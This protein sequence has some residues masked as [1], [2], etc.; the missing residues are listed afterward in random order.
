[1]PYTAGIDFIISGN[2]NV[3][4]GKANITRADITTVTFTEPDAFSTITI[5]GDNTGKADVFSFELAGIPATVPKT[6]AGDLSLFF[7]L[8]SDDI[9]AK[10]N[11]LNKDAFIFTE[12]INQKGNKL[13]EVS[14]IENGLSYTIAYDQ[15]TGIPYSLDAGNDEISVSIIL[16]DF[17]Q[18]DINNT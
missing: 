16:Y 13:T 9:P 2:A 15:H 18:T 11:T 3:T 17:K 6:I 1:M 7:S 8:F 12:K 5:K 10:I 4:K 14:F